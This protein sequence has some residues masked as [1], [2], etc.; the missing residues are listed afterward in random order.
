M[1]YLFS[2]AQRKRPRSEV[3]RV[4]NARLDALEALNP[5]RPVAQWTHLR[6]V[7]ADLWQWPS[8]SAAHG[9]RWWDDSPAPN[10]G[11]TFGMEAGGVGVAQVH[12]VPGV[13]N[14]WQPLHVCMSSLIDTA[15]PTG[16]GAW[17]DRTYDQCPFH[18][19]LMGKDSA[20]VIIDPAVAHPTV[21]SVYFNRL[22]GRIQFWTSWDGRG[23]SSS[24]NQLHQ[25]QAQR[26]RIFGVRVDMYKELQLKE[27]YESVGA[28]FNDFVPGSLPNVNDLFTTLSVWWTPDPTFVPTTTTSTRYGGW[29]YSWAPE[30]VKSRFR[31]SL[32]F[33]EG[34]QLVNPVSSLITP[35]LFPINLVRTGDAVVQR[36]PTER[37][38][39]VFYDKSILITRRLNESSIATPYY[40]G[41]NTLTSKT[42]LDEVD[43]DLKLAI[44]QPYPTLL[45]FD[46]ATGA[47][48]L[49]AMPTRYC[50]YICM[51]PEFSHIKRAPRA[52][53]EPFAA[54]VVAVA[55]AAG[56]NVSQNAAATL[57]APFALQANMYAHDG[58]AAGVGTNL[59]AQTTTYTRFNLRLEQAVIPQTVINAALN[60]YN[61][62]EARGDQAIGR[63]GGDRQDGDGIDQE[64]AAPGGI[65]DAA[66]AAGQAVL[67]AGVIGAYGVV[68]AHEVLRAQGR[69]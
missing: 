39:T 35:N 43:L 48:L 46:P 26:I 23:P 21:R 17:L 64:M 32:R 2:G 5:G 7:P 8:Q 55:T 69:I 28:A 63:G 14:E 67:G 10:A 44:S 12:P 45:D 61:R 51:L 38:F 53:G 20:G 6:S 22:R 49:V 65:V 52:A 57:V 3:D 37:Q 11:S 13:L 33:E 36:Q 42:Q 34:Q 68:H 62:P 56:S 25:N 31:S 15:V 47:D 24:C 18:V 54:A 9:Q 59:P 66:V 30:T 16:A 4:Q 50:L 41:A 19:Q 29:Y 1:A 60:V 40:T 27:L 58:F